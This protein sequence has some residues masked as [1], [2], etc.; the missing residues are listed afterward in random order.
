MSEKRTQQ[1]KKV[2]NQIVD[3]DSPKSANEP[4]RTGIRCVKC[5][6]THMPVRSTR[7]Y[8]RRTIRKRKCRN[9]GWETRTQ[10]LFLSDSPTA[11]G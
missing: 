3:L 2:S 6:C 9:C 11:L 7:H 8:G 10:E 1:A 5:G 4:R